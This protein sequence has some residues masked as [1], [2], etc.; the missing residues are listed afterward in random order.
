MQYCYDTG[1]GM[2]KSCI[3]VAYINDQEYFL[4][5][6]VISTNPLS[7]MPTNNIYLFYY[8][9]FPTFLCVRSKGSPARLRER[10]V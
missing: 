6:Q 10:L 9:I 4:T 1:F 8:F 2:K 7:Y 3:I 5:L